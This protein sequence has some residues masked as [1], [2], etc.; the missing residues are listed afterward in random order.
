MANTP[1]MRSSDLIESVKR[2]IS[3][4]ISQNTFSEEDILK[5]ANE[6]ITTNLVPQMLSYH[7]EFFVTYD[8]V[9]LLPTQIKYPI[10]K[11]AIGLRLRD[12]FYVDTSGNLF[13][14][15]R[16]DGDDKGFFSRNIGTDQTIHKFYLE[17]DNVVL[18]PLSMVGVSGSLRMEYFIRPNQLVLDERAGISKY[19]CKQITLD[20]S[21]IVAGDVI[22]I[23]GGSAIAGTNFMIGATSAITASNLVTYINYKEYAI[24]S[25]GNPATA[26][27]T[28]KTDVPNS[29]Y[30]TSNPE[31]F[32]ISSNSGI[33][34]ESLPTHFVEGMK[35]D[36]I[37]YEGSHKILN[38]DCVLK[39]I[40]GNILYFTSASIPI[41]FVIGDY[42]CT[43][44]ECIVPQV[45]DDLHAG[46]AERVCTRILAAIGDQ[47]GMALSQ[48]KVSDMES[49][50]GTLLDARVDGCPTKI[51]SRNS[52]IRLNKNRF[53]RF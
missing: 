11:R 48:A 22:T 26:I 36:L 37:Q 12:M 49:K 34:V 4:P 38:K 14:M 18:T 28:F 30:T 39:K 53:R 44:Y 41:D 9:P 21:K 2:R 51:L 5:F 7:E 25:N 46:I 35:S 33:E 17:N 50:Q 13:E 27:V 8:L 1:Y 24:A 3:F 19:F 16:I 10:P 52:L 31:G 43:Q 42:V 20:N 15:T 23:C 32:I 40:E 6:E 29:E 45:P 47:T